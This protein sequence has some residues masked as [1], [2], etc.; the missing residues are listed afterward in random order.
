LSFRTSRDHLTDILEGIQLIDTFIAGLDLPDYREDMKTK[1]AVECQL[2]IITE[3]AYRLG[4]E[5]STVCPGPDWKGLRA[6]GTS[7]AMAITRWTTR[8]SGIR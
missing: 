6:M 5:A 3:A 1:S 4:D 2:Q 7:S 8:L